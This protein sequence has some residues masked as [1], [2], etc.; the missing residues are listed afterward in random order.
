MQSVVSDNPEHEEVLLRDGDV[1]ITSTR[2]EIKKTTYALRYVSTM[3]LKTSEPPRFE[4]LVVV[5]ISV[6]ALIALLIYVIAG[7]VE[8]SDALV[9][10]CLAAFALLSGGLIY[11]MN[12]PV[13]TLNLQM[14]NGELVQIHCKSADFMRQMHQAITGAMAHQMHDSLVL[15][16][17][18]TLV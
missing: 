11:W 8:P 18:S 5:G 17:E 9:Y 3:R 14:I 7:R 1:T 10:L 13:H 12:P 2:L 4:A 15:D 16:P 6:L